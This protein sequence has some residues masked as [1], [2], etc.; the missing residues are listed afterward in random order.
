MVALAKSRWSLLFF[1]RQ[2]LERP[3]DLP[4][5]SAEAPGAG[6]ADAGL[7][8]LPFLALALGGRSLS[9]FPGVPG[10]SPVEYLFCLF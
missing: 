7:S 8:P 5:V 4:A 3:A 10:V 2:S 9:A 1:S 6:A